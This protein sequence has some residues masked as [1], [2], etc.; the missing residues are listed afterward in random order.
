MKSQK[1]NKKNSITLKKN[2]IKT[3][4]SGFFLS[5]IEKNKPIVKINGAS[6]YLQ[7]LNSNLNVKNFS[8]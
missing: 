7:N 6:L 4:L 5:L 1:Q 3:A 8:H 2:Q